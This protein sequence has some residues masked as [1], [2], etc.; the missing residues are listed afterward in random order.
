MKAVRLAGLA[1]ALAALAAAARADD[2]NAPDFGSG[3][4]GTWTTDE[5]GLPAYLYTMR[6]DDPRAIWD[7][8]TEP[9]TSLH[10]HQ[11]GNDR[12]NAMAYNL[13]FVKLFDNESGALYLNE[14]EPA[15]GKHSGGFGWVMDGA[16]VLVDRDD[17]VP[18]GAQWERVFGV[19]YFKKRLSVPGLTLTRVV[20]APNHPAGD[21][22]F[23]VSE[24]T[25]EN[26]SGRDQ[27]LDLIEYWDVNMRLIT[28]ALMGHSGGKLLMDR[29]VRL[30]PSSEIPGL[31]RAET[32]K[33]FGPDG[34]YPKKP[35]NVDPD[36]PNLFLYSPDAIPA[37]WIT[38]PVELFR[39]EAPITD[40]GALRA[41][42]LLH[43]D[44]RPRSQKRA[45][46]AARLH[47]SVPTHASRTLHF[48]YGYEKAE[49]I[50]PL[51]DLVEEAAG[52]DSRRN[53]AQV[54]TVAPST[55]LNWLGELPRLELPAD[56]FL[57]REL[58]WDYYYLVSAT[59]YD[60]YYQ[61]HKV[62]QGANYLYYT[63]M[64]GATRDYAAFAVTAA[65]YRPEL[66]REIIKFMLRCQDPN[67]RM[68]YDLSGF[69]K[70]YN[71]PY[72][73][74]D[75]DLW[76]VNAVT[77]YV[78]ATRDFAILDEVEPYYPRDKGV[79]G[80]GWDHVTRSL[81]HLIETVGLGPHGLP[82][83]RLSDWND[84]MT[85]LAARD[86]P[87][88]IIATIRRGESLM[89]AAIA[90]A[91]LPAAAELARRR[92]DTLTAGI[93]DDYV[94]KV[95][96]A[97]NDAWSGDHLL[98][99]YSGRGKPFGDE[100]MFLEPQAWA[101]LQPGILPPEREQVLV[102]KI[103]R[104]LREPSKIGMMISTST[105]GSATTRP[106]EQENGGIWLAINGPATLALARFDPNMAW[107]ELKRNT[108]AWHAHVYPENWFGIWAGPDA[109]NSAVSDRPAE[110]WYMKTPIINTGPQMYPVQ[111][112][113]AHAQTMWALA[114]MAGITPTASGW[115]VE[116]RIPMSS[117]SF[118]CALF[119]LQVS[120]DKISGAV[121][122][123][124]GDEMELRLKLPAGWAGKRLTA[125]ETDGYA[126][127]HLHAR[128]DES[129]SWGVSAK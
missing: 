62:P 99:A 65:Y 128:A 127:L 107:D 35:A 57:E 22:P 43:P 98:R 11:L 122:A 1:L 67:G 117:Y 25:L 48:E 31:L 97:L 129:V 64:D 124:A 86:N 91:E 109:W 94:A 73:P 3:V 49:P 46:L 40:P 80:T 114:R 66:A 37:A 58:R 4:F 38:D 100:V 27:E 115:I 78:F 52:E 92:G 23:V 59:L 16:T 90:C 85:L 39:G 93:V 108:L 8:K 72:R 14:Y 32:R 120:P 36:L 33:R 79:S 15:A 50:E 28:T 81:H 125:T 17:L 103:N 68:F 53:P 20:F 74:G 70:R 61:A 96:K 7:P 118:D 21:L 101:L 112:G 55:M 106:G 102:A 19:G 119:S 75:L 104:E 121:R 41:A 13:G 113:H 54:D 77:E 2:V 18:P 6:S 12:V 82:K 88:D 126:V 95:H 29:S 110:T 34:G 123:V 47:L 24:L 71:N 51:L 5:F 45:C 76:F 44:P 69:G 87:I 105:S 83:L 84:E 30:R 9:R 63:G 56:R 42:G 89:N 111:N 10:W 26:T 60:A 116:P